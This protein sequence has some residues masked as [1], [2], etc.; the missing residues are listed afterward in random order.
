MQISEIRGNHTRLRA[1]FREH[2]RNHDGIISRE[3]AGEEIIPYNR[4]QNPNSLS[5]AELM[6]ARLPLSQ[7]RQNSNSVEAQLFYDAGNYGPLILTPGIGEAVTGSFRYRN[8][9]LNLGYTHLPDRSLSIPGVSATTLHQSAG[10]TRLEIAERIG[11]DTV[12]L[13]MR[14][15]PSFMIARG[16]IISERRATDDLSFY[17][18]DLPFSLSLDLF[19]KVINISAQ[20][21]FMSRYGANPYQS[22]LNLNNRENGHPE[23]ILPAENSDP[24]PFYSGTFRFRVFNN[25]RFGSLSIGVIFNRGPHNSTLQGLFPL[26][27]TPSLNIDAILGY[28]GFFPLTSNQYLAAGFSIEAGPAPT[29][30]FHPRLI[31]SGSV[32]YGLRLD[33]EAILEA[34]VSGRYF[35]NLSSSFNVSST[36]FG[37]T[38]RLRFPSF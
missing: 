29:D 25:E 10:R 14:A 3:E 21:G 22:A 26:H 17:V 20:A 1:Y 11:N 32:T 19:K 4:D 9:S 2:D 35:D 5:E 16:N 18:L 12:S 13:T 31:A 24:L 15:A 7:Q 8:F 33:A 38:I 37:G 28:E 27:S 6:E 36:M 23:R 34:E 30:I